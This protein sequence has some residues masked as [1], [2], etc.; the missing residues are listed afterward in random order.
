M[1]LTRSI[2]QIANDLAEDLQ[3]RA[4]HLQREYLN[5][6]AE[7]DKKRAEFETASNALNRLESFRPLIGGKVQC[8]YCWFFDG[9]SGSLYA[10]GHPPGSDT[11]EDFFRC[12]RCKRTFP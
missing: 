2:Q 8:P 6:Q 1:D 5:A 3:G 7:A 9:E 10:I 12:D 11:R 4:A